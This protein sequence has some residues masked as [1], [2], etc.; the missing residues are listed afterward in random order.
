MQLDPAAAA[1]GFRLSAHDTLPSTNTEALRLA[2]RGEPGP[3]WVTA[4]QQTAG[5]GRR[6]NEWISTPGN[7]F[8]TLLLHDPAPAEAAPQLS[9][10]VGLAVHDAIL[11]CAPALRERLALKWPNDVLYAGQKLAGILIESEMVQT[12]LAVAA[13]IGVNCMHHPVQTE[14][15]ATDLASAGA[16]V[17]ADDLFAA[18]SVTTAQRLTQWR[19]GANF[20]SVRSDWL[21][22]AT[23][24]GEAMRVRLPDRE[25]VGRFEALDDSG[26]LLLRLADATL[27]TITAGDV[28]PVAAT[29]KGAA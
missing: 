23:G 22:R 9:F 1:A 3:L 28:F 27:Q 12:R 17:V 18:L 24:I 15:P 14:Y 7:L 29:P 25:F 11:D 16:T 5:R 10:V 2:R 4:R 13:G 6:G 21:D 20:Q 19:G 8:A 26:R